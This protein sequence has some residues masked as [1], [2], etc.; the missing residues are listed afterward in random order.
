ML[1]LIVLPLLLFISATAFAQENYT[2]FNPTPRDKMREFSIDRPDITESPISVD[3]GH[4]QFEG[5][6]IKWSKASAGKSIE[7]IS[8]M[9]GLYKMGLTKS[10]DIQVGLELHN[11]VK[12]PEGKTIEKGYGSTTIRLKHNFWGND[13]EKKTALGM[14]PYISFPSGNPLKVNSDVTFGIGFPYSYDVSEKLGIGGQSQ[15]D[16]IPSEEGGH[17]MSFFQTIVVG[18]PLIGKMDYFVEGLVTFYDGSSIFNLDGGL[19]Y[20]ISDNVKV[21]IATNIGLN[22]EAPTRVFLGLSFRI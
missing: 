7:T 12:D 6:V 17:D 2:L 4:F 19:I 13:G 1:K 15:F 21:D 11:I 20:N 14:I 9:S 18:G 10:W 22:D 16:F 8:L 5:D 3:P